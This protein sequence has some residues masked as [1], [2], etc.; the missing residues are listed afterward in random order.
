MDGPYDPKAVLFATEMVVLL[1]SVDQWIKSDVFEGKFV[2]SGDDITET[3]ERIARIAD[4][5]DHFPS[6]TP[7]ILKGI[8]SMQRNLAAAARI[9]PLAASCEESRL[10]YDI[11]MGNFLSSLADTTRA[12]PVERLADSFYASQTSFSQ[13]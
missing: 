10:A 12:L 2:L 6:S 3:A 8:E 11:A 4:C 9:A 1:D 7:E 13:S 5:H